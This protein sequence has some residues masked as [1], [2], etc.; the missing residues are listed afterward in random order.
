M[1]WAH[2]PNKICFWAVSFHVILM[3]K[4]TINEFNVTLVWGR[5]GWLNGGEQ[6]AGKLPSLKQCYLCSGFPTQAPEMAYSCSVK[7]ETFPS[8]SQVPRASLLWGGAWIYCCVVLC[9]RSW[10]VAVSP[11]GRVFNCNVSKQVTQQFDPKDNLA[12]VK[13]IQLLYLCVWGVCLYPLHTQ[14]I[15]SLL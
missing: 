3:Y 11:A 12:L 13:D 15:T 14:S 10:G 1:I 2:G 8:C 9:W 4:G 6:S 7:R 5:S